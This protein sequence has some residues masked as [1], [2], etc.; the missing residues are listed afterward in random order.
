MAKATKKAAVKKA[1]PKKA[2][3]KKKKAAVKKMAADGSQAWE[4]GESVQCEPDESE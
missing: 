2:A 4:R 3:V 1:A